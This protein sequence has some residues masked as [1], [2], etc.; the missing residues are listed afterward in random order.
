[1]IEFMK[2]RLYLEG[3]FVP[4]CIHY[5]ISDEMFIKLHFRRS[6]GQFPNLRNPKTLNEKIQWLKLH[7]RTPL[8]TQCADKHAVRQYVTEKIGAEYLVPLLYSTEDPADIVE[9]NLPDAPFIVK[10]THGSGGGMIVRD[11]ST[12]DWKTL[13]K[14]LGKSLWQNYYYLWREWVYKHIKPRIV[15]E[16]LLLDEE[17]SIPFDYKVH[18]FNGQPKIIQVDLDRF[19]NHTRNLY[20]TQWQL[21]PFTWCPW[22][23]GKP[24][25]PNGRDVPAPSQ[26]KQ[27]LHLAETLSSPFLYARVDLYEVSGRLFF[28][29]ITFFHEA[30]TARLTP[31]E[32]D[33]KLGDMLTLPH[34][35][36]GTISEVRGRS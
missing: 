36:H 12:I 2:R 33:R 19:T 1:M 17:G 11:K 5:L 14:A 28:G 30:G 10:V 13:R 35:D 18:C 8:H 24:S 16:Q 15:V 34:E 3:C 31:F 4:V 29:E 6:F 9:E 21:Q 32:W 22:K 25:Y 23:Q 7:D 27:M 20:D 26:L